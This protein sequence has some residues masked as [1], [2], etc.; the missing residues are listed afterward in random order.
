M[1]I[2]MHVHT[3]YSED[4]RLSPSKIIEMELKAGI[5]C[6]AVTDHNN[7]KS[8]SEFKKSGLKIIKG[9][10]IATDQGHLIG[11]FIEEAIKTKDFYETCDNIKTQGGISILPHPFRS[12]KNPDLL[13]NNIDVIE[14]FNSRT[15]DKLNMKAFDLAKEKKLPKVCGSDAHFH[16]EL[17]KGIIEVDSESTEEARKKILKGKVKLYGVRS[18]SYVHTMTRTIIALNK[19]NHLVRR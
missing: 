17:S 3:K 6:I 5:D 10:E 7:F 14:A 18:P 2:D 4:C 15:S 13:A 8:F 11:I 9:E 16:F 1:K 19:L 12:H